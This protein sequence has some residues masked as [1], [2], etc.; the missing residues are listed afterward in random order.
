[1]SSQ[2]NRSQHDQNS[3]NN[4]AVPIIGAGI[5][6]GG[7]LGYGGLGGYGGGL[8]LGGGLGIGG[9]GGYGGGLGLGGY[10][11]YGG[12]GGGLGLGG[13]GGYGG[14][15]GGLGLGGYGGYGGYGGGLGY[16][17]YGGGYFANGGIGPGIINANRYIN[18]QP[19]QTTTP[20]QGL[21]MMK[22]IIEGSLPNKKT[23]NGPINYAPMN[24]AARDIQAKIPQQMD[25][26]QA[27]TSQIPRPPVPGPEAPYAVQQNT[28]VNRN[29]QN[30]A[31][32]VESKAAYNL[33]FALNNPDSEL[34][35]QFGVNKDKL[36]NELTKTQKDNTVKAFNH[37]ETN[38]GGIISTIMDYIISGLQALVGNGSFSQLK[39]ERS[40]LRIATTAYKNLEKL[41]HNVD[42]IQNATGLQKT[43]NSDKEETFTPIVDAQGKMKGM[44]G[45]K[46][47]EK[48]DPEILDKKIMADRGIIRSDK[49]NDRFEE[50][51]MTGARNI[52]SDNDVQ[53]ML[54]KDRREHVQSGQPD[55]EARRFISS[56]DNLTKINAIANTIINDPE[57]NAK[58][59]GHYSFTMRGAEIASEVQKRFLKEHNVLSHKFAI[60]VPLT[61]D[62]RN[63]ITR[64]MLE[65]GAN[66]KSEAIGKLWAETAKINGIDSKDSEMLRIVIDA[67]YANPE[68]LIKTPNEQG[69]ELANSIEKIPGIKNIKA[70]DN[71]IELMTP[72]TSKA[73]LQIAGM[74]IDSSLPTQGIATSLLSNKSVPESVSGLMGSPTTP[75][76]ATD[77][78]T[79]AKK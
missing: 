40:S 48:T 29:Y 34:A 51:L 35:K 58:S 42:F 16:G 23:Y 26:Q 7:G 18:N 12:Y 61:S 52:Y 65:N 5:G 27:T 46:V 78:N 21:S 72:R 4:Q 1:M 66:K 11:G 41:D 28:V 50:L 14:Y 31:L 8:G 47:Q 38:S 76:V 22:G 79:Q 33:Q 13:Y 39:T 49:Q 63:T 75:K 17:G 71:L 6:Y 67:K 73:V 56:N 70:I 36:V 30:T 37:A 32:D 59:S 43:V 55:D 44:I 10:G 62:I 9:L 77:K 24:A 60:E 25:L 53:E 54:A 3:V 64:H 20:A 74:N 57:L 68:F 2:N 69:N 15:G 45:F 19:R